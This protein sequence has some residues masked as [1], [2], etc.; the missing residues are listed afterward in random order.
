M[1]GATW[2]ETDT[3]AA[4]W[5][6]QPDR[7]KAGVEHR[8]PL[9][10]QAI[11]VLAAAAPMANGNGLVFPARRGGPINRTTISN[12]MRDLK[13][14]AVPHGFRWSFRDWAAEQ[15]SAPH[16]VMEAALA[17][18][19]PNHVEAAYFRSDLLEKR[20]EL[21]QRWADYVLGT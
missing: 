10:T 14:A 15:M 16:A 12:L 21:M 7:M 5:I 1:C 17:H 11:E 19:V 13:I 20:R 8:V 2:S 6:V 4:L 3:G 9:S 18:Q